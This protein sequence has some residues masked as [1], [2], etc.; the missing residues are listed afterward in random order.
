MAAR[1]GSSPKPKLPVC[2][3]THDGSSCRK[4]GDHHCKP[5]ADHVVAFFSEVLVHT[6]GRYAR[7]PFVP[8]AWQEKGIL[9]PLF[10]EVVWSAEQG[11]YVRRYVVAWIELGRKNGKSESLAG[12]MLYLLV[13]D[14]EES[15]EIFGCARNREQASL[16]FDVAPRTVQL[17]PV[18]S[19]RLQVKARVKRN[20]PPK[21]NSFH[22]AYP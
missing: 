14:G 15:A 3:W 7:T 9:R 10:G 5:R 2:G 16:V 1:T 11:E 18:L 21:T 13:A 6:K 17:S 4:R 8:T 19:R 22:G 20:I 12:I